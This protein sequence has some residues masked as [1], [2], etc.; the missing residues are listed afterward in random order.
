[1][2]TARRVTLGYEPTAYICYKGDLSVAGCPLAL[3]MDDFHLI[4]SSAVD[5]NNYLPVL[6]TPRIISFT[7][8]CF[9]ELTKHHKVAVVATYKLPTYVAPVVP[10]P[11]PK[12]KPPA[13]P[14]AEEKKTTNT[15]VATK[16][17]ITTSTSEA[18][19]PTTVTST[20]TPE[21][22]AAAPP[23]PP[24]IPP[25]VPAV[26]QA[27]KT[28]TPIRKRRAT[29]PP[30]A[31]SNSSNLVTITSNV[32]RLSQWAGQSTDLIQLTDDFPGAR[33]QSLKYF[34]CQAGSY[35]QINITIRP[36]IADEQL[37]Y[38]GD[39][40]VHLHFSASQNG[41]KPR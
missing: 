13:V 11:K 39:V 7:N 14:K 33:N 8:R 3:E 30:A 21:P 36:A 22:T 9:L 40:L 38:T 6:Q 17:T 23:E 31:V 28:V 5:R 26:E 20:E 29:A 18:S 15:D 1:V 4:L 19:A 32:A 16:T 35:S 25:T 10:K 37:N 24:E 34:S 2:V 12:P 41:E 27:A